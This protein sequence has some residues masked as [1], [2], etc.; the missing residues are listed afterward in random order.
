MKEYLLILSMGMI[1][2]K[3][4]EYITNLPNRRFNILY[5]HDEDRCDLYDLDNLQKPDK[6]ELR[7][8]IEVLKNDTKIR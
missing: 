2:S 4:H 5:T 1:G 7:E 3:Q 8:L 6:K